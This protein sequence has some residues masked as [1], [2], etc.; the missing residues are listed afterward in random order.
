MT[1]PLEQVF[2]L[3]LL[4]DP[5]VVID[6]I[7]EYVIRSLAALEVNELQ[8]HKDPIDHII[9]AQAISHRMTLISS[10]TKFPFYRKQGLDLIVNY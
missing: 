5:S 9:I 7:D 6:N 10:D 2:V 8:A 4:H 1:Y 3:L